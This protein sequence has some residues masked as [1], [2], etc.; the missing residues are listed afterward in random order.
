MDST[1]SSTGASGGVQAEWVLSCDP[2]RFAELREKSE[3]ALLLRL[4][5]HANALRFCLRALR[6]ELADDGPVGSRARPAAFFYYSGSLFEA[7]DLVQEL[8]AV[9]GSSPHWEASFGRF[10]SEAD[11]RALIARYS[12][13]HT[14]RNH[15]GFHVAAHV[16]S[17][18][19]GRLALPEY[20]VARG[21]GSDPSTI[22]Y[23][24]AD[25]M[26]AHYVFGSQ[27]EFAEFE[28]A[29]VERGTHITSLFMDFLA[30][31]DTLTMG[32]LRSWGFAPRFVGSSHS[33]QLAADSRAE[34]AD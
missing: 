10:G 30:S 12:D 6:A 2:V 4:G 8:R 31:T 24:L 19:L 13:L 26:A 9:F 23:E 17:Q 5:R 28:A 25:T 15:V 27:A 18:S 33:D 1:K 3:F 21:A 22:F 14:V 11:V 34:A 16:P 20:V 29:F 32:T 7:F